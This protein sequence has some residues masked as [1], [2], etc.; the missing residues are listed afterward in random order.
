IAFC[1]IIIILIGLSQ[2]I[3]IVG[4]IFRDSLKLIPY[5]V[6]GQFDPANLLTSLILM[7]LAPIGVKLGY[8]ILNKI[9]QE[10]IYRYLYIVLFLSGLKLIYDSVF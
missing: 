9:R 2:L 5:A 6:L 8:I 10:V 3:C 7:P 4:L 1:W